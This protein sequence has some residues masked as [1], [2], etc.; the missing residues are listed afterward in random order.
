[1]KRLK[2]F[3]RGFIAFMSVI[4]LLSAA[5]AH[6]EIYSGEGSYVMSEG[7]NLGV[8]K[9]RAK[10]DAMRNAA[11]KAGTYVKSYSRARNFELE[12]DVIETMTANILKLIGSPNFSPLKEVDNLE[13]VLI[14]VIVKVQIDDSDILRW[15]KK[16]EQEKSM[17]VAQNKALRK[18]NEEQARQIAELK[19]QLAQST[20][21]EDSERITNEFANEDK[22]FLSNQKVEEANKL[23]ERI[24]YKGAIKLYDKAVQLNTNNA[25]AY[26][27]R[28][29]A[30]YS[31]KQYE[32]AIQNYNKAININP[33]LYQAYHNRGIVYGTLGQYDWAIQ[34]FDKVIK[35]NPNFANA[36]SC[37]GLAYANIGKYNNAIDDFT[38]AIVHLEPNISVIYRINN[39]SLQPY[40]AF[41]LNFAKLYQMRGLCYKKI[42]NDKKAKADFTKAKELGY[43]G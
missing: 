37:R 33:D 16:D 7:E 36:Y 3:R 25:L 28:G 23:H 35:L 18:A 24:D 39:G 26:F 11:E 13:G 40:K 38:Y 14:H 5:V 20:T 9:E 17:L 31:L 6:A 19:R 8:A 43:N 30:Y 42:G 32:L 15:L 22:I 10:A 1:M 41:D 12:E 27:G 29:N 4:F 2:S 21:K 34:N